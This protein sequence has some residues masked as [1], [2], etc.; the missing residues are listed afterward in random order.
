MLTRIIIG[1]D[2][3][4]IEIGEAVI[5]TSPVASFLDIPGFSTIVWVM[6]DRTVRGLQHVDV[7]TL[8][9]NSPLRAVSIWDIDGFWPRLST[10]CGAT[11]DGVI[12]IVGRLLAFLQ[13]GTA[14][15][16]DVNRIALERHLRVIVK[17]RTVESLHIFQ[18]APRFVLLH[19]W[20]NILGRNRFTTIGRSRDIDITPNHIVIPRQIIAKYC[21][22]FSGDLYINQ[23][24]NFINLLVYESRATV[25]GGQ[26][27][28]LIAVGVVTRM[29]ESNDQCLTIA[30][31]MWPSVIKMTIIVAAFLTALC[32]NAL[33]EGLSRVGRI[34]QEQLTIV[35]IIRL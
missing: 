24:L 6:Y 16:N 31:Y 14:A 34:C 22:P 18:R 19:Y 27:T 11:E 2:I 32:Q 5:A 9:C 12:T 17:W 21:P 33:L 30:Y 4:F 20:C 7:V 23:I 28:C 13:L 29:L 26:H 35:A 8:G 25:K 1:R 3:E 15:E 10:I